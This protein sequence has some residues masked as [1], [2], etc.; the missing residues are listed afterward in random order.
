VCVRAESADLTGKFETQDIRRRTGRGWI[1]A[2]ALEDIGPIHACRVHADEDLVTAW[3]TWGR[4]VGDL[5][6]FWTAECAESERFHEGRQRVIRKSPSA[7]A[8]NPLLP[9]CRHFWEFW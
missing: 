1:V 3:R 9:S 4:N 5:Q 6:D 8:S 2:A 7:M